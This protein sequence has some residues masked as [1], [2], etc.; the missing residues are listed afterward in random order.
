MERSAGILL[1]ISSLPGNQGI[2]DF[3]KYAYTWIDALQ[4]N[5]IKLWQILPLHPLGYGNSPYQSYSTYAG[6]PIYI[7]IDHLSDLGLLKM[8]S[9]RNYRKFQETVDYEGVRAFKA[10]YF[11]KRLP[12]LKKY[13]VNIRKHTIFFVKTVHGWKCMRRI[14]H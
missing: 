12:I 5:G 13:F 9:I 3:G 10:P 14:W 7:N 2:G 6:D 1:A 8:S 11:K 4:E